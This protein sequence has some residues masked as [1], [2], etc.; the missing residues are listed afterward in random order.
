MLV[1]TELFNIRVN[2]FDADKSAHYSWVL[3]VSGTQC[4]EVLQP[5]GDN[6]SSEKVLFYAD[7]ANSVILC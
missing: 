3:V 6:S 4:V 5:S 1:V 2:D 7:S